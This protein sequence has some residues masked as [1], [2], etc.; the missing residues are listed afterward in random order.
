M[1]PKKRT[2][3]VEEVQQEGEDNQGIHVD[4]SFYTKMSNERLNAHDWSGC[5][6]LAVV[7]YLWLCDKVT[8]AYDEN[9]V[10][11]GVVMFGRPVAF[12]TIANDR[13]LDSTWRAVQRNM[14]HL[15]DR[16]FIRRR[17]HQTTQGYSYEVIGCAREVTPEGAVKGKDGKVYF[18]TQKKKKKEE[19]SPS[20][21]C[22]ICGLGLCDCKCLDELAIEYAAPVKP[23]MQD[24]FIKITCPKC[25][26]TS[27]MTQHAYD[28]HVSIC[29][30]RGYDEPVK[31][32]PPPAPIKSVPLPA[33]VEPKC[34]GCSKPINKCVCFKCPEC[35][36]AHD[37][38]ASLDECKAKHQAKR[39][40]KEK[41]DREWGIEF[42]ASTA[43]LNKRLAEAKAK[44][45]EHD[46][47]VREW[48][49]GKEQPTL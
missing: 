1:P 22:G 23:V 15:V 14:Q 44:K 43:A 12:S 35:S 36:W 2:P 4:P 37:D 30:G 6:G 24:N 32:T 33:P 40:A 48:V 26:L 49:Y 25:R 17:R 27:M 16:G 5:S 10:A 46:R 11:I 42:A 45:E 39:E 41:E 28:N 47:Q 9:G 34:P 19:P 13:N 21:E 18:D 31:T 20:L 38:Q 29:T 7:L 8:E 3:P